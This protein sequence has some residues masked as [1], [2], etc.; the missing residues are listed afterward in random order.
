[1]DALDVASDSGWGATPAMSMS[2]TGVTAQSN[3]GGKGE[4][5]GGRGQGGLAGTGKGLM[6]RPGQGPKPTE[7]P[8]APD[9]QDRSLEPVVDAREVK[10]TAKQANGSHA[11]ACYSLWP[12]LG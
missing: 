5:G 9:V 4:G 3:R 2:K 12:G 8:T 7:T 11:A 1:M 10:R 6:P